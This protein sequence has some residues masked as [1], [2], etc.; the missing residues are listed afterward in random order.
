[1]NKVNTAP[2]VGRNFIRFFQYA[3]TALMLTA[4]S[5]TALAEKVN[6][7]TADA[8]ALQYIPGI[9]PG[10]SAEIIRVRQE[11]G[12][13]NTMEDLLAVPGI[14]EKTLLNVRKFGALNS[15]V[16][17]PHRGD[18]SQPTD[19]RVGGTRNH[20]C[21]RCQQLKPLSVVHHGGPATVPFFFI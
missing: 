12:G 3:L 1:M 5:G 16:S 10:K 14:G 13:F 2:V 21:N 11:T 6:L 8:E 17:A 20:R 18:G 4:F 9:G 7:N 19:Q 15:G